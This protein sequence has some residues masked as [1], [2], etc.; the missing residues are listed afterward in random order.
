MLDMRYKVVLNVNGKPVT[1]S[2]VSH[3]QHPSLIAN[4]NQVENQVKS[5]Q[6]MS[7]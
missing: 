6:I 7:C 4:F 5:S 1:Q 2:D 3:V